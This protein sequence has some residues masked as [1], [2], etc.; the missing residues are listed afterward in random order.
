MQL[1]VGCQNLAA[2]CDI[3][4]MALWRFGMVVGGLHAVHT[5][6]HVTCPH[7]Q[8]TWRGQ[9]VI[10]VAA[11]VCLGDAKGGGGAG[12]GAG[13]GVPAGAPASQYLLVLVME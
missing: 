9:S 5:R 3:I 6:H 12:A 13:A 2:G 7:A 8:L 10:V 11:T 1:S 4:L